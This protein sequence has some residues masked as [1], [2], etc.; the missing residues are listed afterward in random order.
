MFNV[1]KKNMSS[2]VTK[3]TDKRLAYLW[4]SVGTYLNLNNQRNRYRQL[5]YFNFDVTTGPYDNE[6]SAFPAIFNLI[7]SQ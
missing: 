2:H 1:V 5:I 6:K 3:I 7:P 4:A